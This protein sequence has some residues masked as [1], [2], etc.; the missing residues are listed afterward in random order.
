MKN[1]MSRTDKAIRLSV[2]ALI[3]LLAFAKVIT[4]TWAIILIILAGVFVLTSILGLC[5]LYLLFGI[6]TNKKQE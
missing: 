1:N 6:S 5:P 4:G 3:V 2:A